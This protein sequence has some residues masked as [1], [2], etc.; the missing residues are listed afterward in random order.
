MTLGA[1]A[2][3]GEG[4]VF[5]VVV[6]LCEGPVAAFIDDLLRARKVEGLDATRGERLVGRVS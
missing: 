2:D 6:K 4:V 5:E 3:E 1:I